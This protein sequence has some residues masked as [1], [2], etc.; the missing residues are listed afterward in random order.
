M[1][2]TPFIIL[3]LVVIVA[4]CCQ[5]AYKYRENYKNLPPGVGYTLE[6]DLDIQNPK[7]QK[8]YTQTYFMFL[9]QLFAALSSKRKAYNTTL[10]EN[11]AK[12]TIDSNA[13][14]K[15]NILVQPVLSR[16][17]EVAPMTEFWQVGYETW[18]VYKIDNSPL[19]LNKIDMF[20]YDRIGWTELRILLEICELPKGNPTDC[21]KK[22]DPS[23]VSVAEKTTP[24]F[25]RYWVGYPAHD[26]LIPLPDEVIVSEKSVENAKGVNYAIPCPYEK[27]WI[28]NI[29]I[30]NSNLTLDAFENYSGVSL[31]GINRIPF[32]YTKYSGDNNPIQ[33]PNRVNNQWITL[34]TQPKNVNAYPCTPVPFVWDSL[35]LRP[36]VHPTRRC[37]GVRTATTQQPLT[38]SLDPS[39]FQYPRNITKYTWM[40]DNTRIIPALQYIGT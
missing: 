40:F 37:P 6:N 25:P 16:I 22:G 14:D 4:I 11:H 34:D 15:L 28:N 5:C 8:N 29:E 9:L 35:G 36:E 7:M 30:V 2:Y 1:Y 10:L 33:F 26:Q 13:Q 3:L 17:K 38:T 20:I 18:K 23:F 21:R 27:I 24:E 39:M 12:N 31:P 32:D 19:L